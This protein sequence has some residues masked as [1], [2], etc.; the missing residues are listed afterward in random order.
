MRRWTVL[1]AALVLAATTALPAAAAGFVEPATRCQIGWGSPA[2]GRSTG[3]AP[4][5]RG[6]RSGEH[7]CFDRLVFEAPGSSPANP[8]GYHVRYTDALLQD[9]SGH[10]LPVRGSAVLEVIVDAPAYDRQT[11]APTI[12]ARSGQPLP[13]VDLTGYRTF[14]D[15][16][17]G[18]SHEGRTQI[19]LGLHTRL[20]YRILQLDNRLVIDVAHTANGTEQG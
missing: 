16:V 19:G 10:P 7:P 12:P 2:E 17:F 20:P 14:Q 15:T 8:V 5:L 1:P 4:E 13:G 11:M 6:I 3:Q 9:A 18:A